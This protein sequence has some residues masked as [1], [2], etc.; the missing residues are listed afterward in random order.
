MLLLPF[1]FG[2]SG[3]AN[4]FVVSGFCI[5]VSFK[6]KPDWPGFFVR[7]FFR[8]YPPY[9]IAVLLFA[10]VVPW[11]RISFSLFDAVQLG[12]H[13]SLLHNLNS[14]TFFGFSPAFWSIAVEAQLYLLYPVLLALVSRFGWKRTLI[15]IAV[16]E[17]ALR[18]VCSVLLVTKGA[19]P[20]W[21]TGIPM[22]YWFSWSIGAAIA[23]AYVS[24]RSVPFANQSLVFW[25][26]IALASTFAKPLASFSFL[27]FALMTATAIAKLLLRPERTPSFFPPFL[28]K[29]LQT[30]GLW[31]YS[32]YLLHQPFLMFLHLRL[33]PLVVFLICLGLWFPIVALSGLWY[34]AFELPSIALGKRLMRT[35]PDRA[36]VQVEKLVDQGNTGIQEDRQHHAA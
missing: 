11:T 22:M 25:G 14:R 16:L 24:G 30:V 21:L 26:G 36:V 34:R 32:I 27:F 33:H 35:H 2:G 9:A 7:R 31:S 15:Y 20:L 1:R 28:S 12:S 10:L 6:R 29:Y 23:E 19:V 3:V 17:I 5:H 8:I 4:F 18:G 13:L